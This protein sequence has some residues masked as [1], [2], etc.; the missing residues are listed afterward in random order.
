M[1]YK[2]DN[3]VHYIATGGLFDVLVLVLG[4]APFCWAL[5][6]GA[7]IDNSSGYSSRAQPW[8]SWIPR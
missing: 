5:V 3:G 6:P 1:A 7:Q 4:G 8:Q 2:H